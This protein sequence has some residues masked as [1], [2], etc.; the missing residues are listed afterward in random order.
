MLAKPQSD[1]T[2]RPWSEGDLPLLERLMGD[3]AMMDHLGGPES[4]EKI[5]SRHARYCQ[6]STTGKDGM[7]VIFVGPE[8]APAGS[9]GYWEN[10]WQGQLIWETGWSV[11]P[12]F[13]G[14]GIATRAAVA[15]VELARAEATYRFIHAFPSVDNPPSNA[16]CRKAGFTLL[17]EDDFEYPPGHWMRCNNWRLDLF[18]PDKIA[19]R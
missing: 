12:E 6:P 4:P 15:V 1:L 16:I 3:P 5:R 17:G 8:K 11:L 7:F 10:T 13:Q 19:N 9:I 14:Q 2:L 18:E